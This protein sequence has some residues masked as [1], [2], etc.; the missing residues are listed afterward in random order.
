MLCLGAAASAWQRRRFCSIRL[1]PVPCFCVFYPLKAAAVTAALI[2]LS[3]SVTA[4]QTKV[5]SPLQPSSPAASS[6]RDPPAEPEASS[7]SSAPTFLYSSSSVIPLFCCSYLP[8]SGRFL[9]SLLFLK[10]MFEG[11][12]PLSASAGTEPT[13]RPTDRTEPSEQGLIPDLPRRWDRPFLRRHEE[14]EEDALFRK[15]IDLSPSLSLSLP[16]P[17]PLSLPFFPNMAAGVG[18]PV[19][20]SA[21]SQLRHDDRRHSHLGNKRVNEH[22]SELMNKQSA[23]HH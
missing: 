5:C 15:L 4:G 9:S 3:V 16:P 14:E 18:L 10:K 12:S 7:S 11:S 22:V 13:D 19:R 2:Q 1:H 21:A 8:R 17:L 6:A 23:I 20:Q